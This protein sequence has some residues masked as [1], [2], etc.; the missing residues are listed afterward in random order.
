MSKTNDLIIL[1]ARILLSVM[2]IMSGF[3]KLVNPAG[4]AGMITGA[5]LPAADLL[6]Y[7]AGLFELV[8]GLFVLVGFQTKLTGWALALFCVFTGL[9]FHSSAINVPDFPAAANGWLT[10][11]NQIMLMKNITLGGAYIL[12]ATFGPGA[13]SIDARRGVV[14]TA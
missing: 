4:T 12:L 11:F 6:A 13:Y 8:A 9:V 14:V 3:D 2:F 1:V 10:V 5:G 7:A